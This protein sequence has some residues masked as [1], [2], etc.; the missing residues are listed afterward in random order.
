MNFKKLKEL[1][2]T[3]QGKMLILIGGF[4]VVLLVAFYSVLALNYGSPLGPVQALLGQKVDVSENGDNGFSIDQVQ[5]GENKTEYDAFVRIA[6]MPLMTKKGVTGKEIVVTDGKLKLNQ[7]TINFALATDDLWL[8]GGD[9]YYYYKKALAPGERTE[10][11]LFTHAQLKHYNRAFKDATLIVDATQ[12][13]ITTYG[14][15]YR[16]EWWAGQTPRQGKLKAVDQVLGPIAM[17]DME[18]NIGH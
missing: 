4:L 9:G 10:Q 11:P 3:T 7:V 17:S 12:E 2:S 14:Y 8:D 6:V 1:P 15:A 13:T 18:N 5:Y 16:A